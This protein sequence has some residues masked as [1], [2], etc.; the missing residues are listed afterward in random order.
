MYFIHQWVFY[1]FKGKTPNSAH[2]TRLF[3][4]GSHCLPGLSLTTA[5]REPLQCLRHTT[6]PP[7]SESRTQHS[8]CLEGSFS[9]G[10]FP[11]YFQ[12]SISV[13]SLQALLSTCP[14][15]LL[16]KLCFLCGVHNPHVHC[17]LVTYTWMVP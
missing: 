9:S 14:L 13:S 4:M 7:V 3:L 11:L 6:C 10:K 8:L 17:R 5:H 2:H 12:N 1:C 16:G 15:L